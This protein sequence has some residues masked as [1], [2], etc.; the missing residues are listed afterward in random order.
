MRGA[1]LLFG[2]V[3]VAAVDAKTVYLFRH[4]IRSCDTSSLQEYAAQPFPEW[5]VSIRPH[6]IPGHPTPPAYPPPC[7]LTYTLTSYN[8]LQI[9]R[10]NPMPT[11]SLCRSLW[12]IACREG[13]RLCKGLACTS[14]QCPRQ[15]SAHASLLTTSRV[16]LILQKHWSVS[17]F[18]LHQQDGGTPFLR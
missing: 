2:V 15:S 1:F 6:L 7:G 9:L 18:A 4:C 16:T 17:L 13:W 5:N 8:V 14:G 3:A 11:L 12:I 10:L